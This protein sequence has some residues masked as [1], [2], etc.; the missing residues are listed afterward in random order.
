MPTTIFR[1]TSPTNQNRPKMKISNFCIFCSIW[2]KFGIWANNGPKITWY[3]FEMVTATYYASTKNPHIPSRTIILFRFFI[4][5]NPYVLLHSN[6]HKTTTTTTTTT[7]RRAMAVCP[8]ELSSVSCGGKRIDAFLLSLAW[9]RALSITYF[10]IYFVY[11]YY[12]CSQILF[13]VYKIETEGEKKIL[14]RDASS[15][16]RDCQFQS[17]GARIEAEFDIDNFDTAS[18]RTL[19]RTLLL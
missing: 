19:A 14:K 15:P 5:I 8:T 3:K 18:R 9:A 1:P 13:L 10:F 7:D 6:I 16:G 11:I 4:K 17:I 2:I 12:I